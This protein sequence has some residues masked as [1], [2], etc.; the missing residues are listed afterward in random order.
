MRSDFLHRNPPI[1]GLTLLQ[2]GAI[3]NEISTNSNTLARKMTPAQCTR[4]IPLVGKKR[5]ALYQSLSLTLHDWFVTASSLLWVC[6]QYDVRGSSLL[7]TQPR[8]PHSTLSL[9][10]CRIFI[11]GLC[12]DQLNSVIRLLINRGACASP[13]IFPNCLQWCLLWEL[14]PQSENN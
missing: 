14:I 12:E 6:S 8:Q 4:L 9:C 2:T 7:L 5:F 3:E 1:V 13:F 11:R 10:I